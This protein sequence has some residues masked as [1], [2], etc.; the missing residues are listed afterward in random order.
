MS[1]KLNSILYPIT[2][3][4]GNEAPTH[5]EFVLLAPEVCSLLLPE[6]VRLDDVGGVDAVAEVVL[7]HLQDRLDRAPAGVAPH[8][9][10]HAV[11][12]LPNIVAETRKYETV[13]SC[14]VF[15]M[16]NVESQV[17]QFPSYSI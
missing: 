7:Q 16:S 4:G 8:V 12:E 3:G 14:I 1:L 13:L 17:L 6:V 9:D 15:L 2:E 11:P 10:H 5:L